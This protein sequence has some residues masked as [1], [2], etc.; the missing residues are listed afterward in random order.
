MNYH[1]S[2]TNA[3][4]VLAA[5]SHPSRLDILHRLLEGPTLVSELSHHLHL[6]Q[7]NLSNHL[8]VLRGA[9]L[10]EVRAEGRRRVYELANPAVA[11]LVESVLVLSDPPAASPSPTIAAARTC[12]DH[13]A[14]RL[15]VSIFNALKKNRAFRRD[16]SERGSLVL[17]KK[18]TRLLD[19]AGIDVSSL[20]R[21]RRRLAFECLDWTERT[22]H[23]GG[24]LGAA[25]CQ[26]A[27]QSGWI[28]RNPANRAVQVTKRGKIELKRQFGVDPSALD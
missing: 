16:A 23:I 28:E 5:I 9:R 25:I 26:L 24:S 21:A 15:G 8:K 27:V 12:Y 11:S 4:P 22:A 13:L 10:V 18:G 17:T 6:S 14:G 7:S 1:C 20:S 2:M 19:N 3:N